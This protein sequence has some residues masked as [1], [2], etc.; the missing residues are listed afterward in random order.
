MKEMQIKYGCNPHQK[1]SRLFVQEGGLPLEVLNGTPSYINFLDALHAWQLVRE[2]HEATGLPAAA[3]FKHVSPAGAAVA[4]DL[5]PTLAQAC[6]VT[7]KTLSPVATAYARARGADRVSSFGDFIAVSDVV[8]KS[9]ADLLA[10]EVSDGIVAPAYEPAALAKLQ[11]KRKGSYVILR[12][13][14]AWQPGEMERRDVFGITLEQKRNNVKI[15]AS[16]FANRVTERKELPE[17]AL[18]DLIIA[19]ITLKYTQSNSIC[20]AVDGQVIGVGA[21]QQSRIHCTRLAAGKADIWMFRQHPKVLGLKFREGLSNSVRDNA[22]DQFLRDDVTEVELAE[23]RTLFEEIPQKLTVQEKADFIRSFSGIVYSSDAFIPFRDNIDRAAASGA[24][25]V[26]QAGGSVRD[27][28]VIAAADTYGMVMC[29]TG[30][31][32]FHH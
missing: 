29:N 1:P 19:T 24:R 7:G 10:K 18:R 6:H 21:G 20:F 27:E 28:E 31:R 13:D 5:T 3:S 9:L 8:D 23:W 14:P 15:D 22:V 12:M 2:L 30:L 32:L 26:A 25:Y 4:V 17:A 11:A 16:L